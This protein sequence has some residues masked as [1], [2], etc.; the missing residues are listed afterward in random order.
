MTDIQTFDDKQ[1][2]TQAAAK[3]TVAALQA[4]IANFGS[5][6]WVLAGGSTPLAA[7]DVL[8]RDY[9]DALDWQKVTVLL[10]DERIG[11]LDGP[12]SN[13]HALESSIRKLRMSELRPRS[14]RSAEDAAADYEAQLLERLPKSSL[15][16]PRLD[17]V[18]LGVGEDGHTLSLFPRHESILPTNRLVTA[19]HDS[20]KPPADRISLTLRALLGARK[21]IVIATG[22]DKQAAVSAGSKQANSPIGLATD[23]VATHDGSVTWLV[24]R[25]AAPTD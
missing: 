8:A 25:A 22:A 5:A 16:L 24:D 11:N 4:A 14:D 19:V 3:Q 18:W 23:I 2:V 17:V 21:V 9:H 10:G 20:P 15:G 13:W 12:D 6:T 1:E 7:Y